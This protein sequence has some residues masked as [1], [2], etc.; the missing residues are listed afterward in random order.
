MLS[1]GTSWHVDSE[2]RADATAVLPL[3]IEKL[4]TPVFEE[5]KNTGPMT[6]STRRMLSQLFKKLL[7]PHISG[8]VSQWRC[9]SCFCSP[10]DSNTI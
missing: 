5:G 7:F 2:L 4:G 1:R 10:C 8:D 3:C 9:V 6:R